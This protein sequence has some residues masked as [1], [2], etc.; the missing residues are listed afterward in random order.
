MDYHYDYGDG[1]MFKITIIDGCKDLIRDKRIT[2]EKF[3]ELKQKCITDCGPVFIA[4]DG[5]NLVDDVG[6]VGD[7]INFLETL[8]AQENGLIDEKEDFDYYNW[9]H[10]N[11]GWVKKVPSG[12]VF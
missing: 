6:G 1:W 3:E 8:N 10:S 2:K 12:K 5:Y 11:F 9:A 4:A 7:F